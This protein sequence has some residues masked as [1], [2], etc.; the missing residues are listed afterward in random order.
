MEGA[1][2]Q[3]RVTWWKSTTLHLSISKA[4]KRNRLQGPEVFLF[5]TADL[6]RQFLHVSLSALSICHSWGVKM[7][8]SA[9]EK[10]RI[11]Q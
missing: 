9:S 2:Q 1:K 10:R 11:W 4:P 7:F 5:C 3:T 8:D 6:W